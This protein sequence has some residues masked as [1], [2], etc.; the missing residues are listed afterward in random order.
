MKLWLIDFI[1][2]SLSGILGTFVGHPLD[3]IKC[4]LQVHSKEYSN[5]FNSL[6]KIVKEEKLSGLFKGVV[7]PMLNQFP[8]NAM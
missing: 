3:T 2:G 1:S 7:P 4:R 8:I 5:T 6:R